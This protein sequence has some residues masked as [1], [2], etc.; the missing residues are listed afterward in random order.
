MEFYYCLILVLKRLRTKKL[1]YFLIP[2][3]FLI[4]LDLFIFDHRFVSFYPPYN[5]DTTEH[6]EHGPLLMHLCPPFG[7]TTWAAWWSPPKSPW[8]PEPWPRPRPLRTFT[9]P[10]RFITS[11]EIPGCLSTQQVRGLLCLNKRSLETQINLLYSIY[12]DRKHRF[13]KENKWIYRFKMVYFWLGRYCT[14]Q[15]ISLSEFPVIYAWI[16]SWT[17]VYLFWLQ[18]RF[19]LIFHLSCRLQLW[20]FKINETVDQ[21]IYPELFWKQKLLLPKTDRKSE[22]VK[23]ILIIKKIFVKVNFDHS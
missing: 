4:S 6:Q 13:G 15:L 22:G 9:T 5:R 16:I 18:V 14:N 3:K 17:V 8:S 7:Y 1:N 2:F 12:P 23:N 20:R 21:V 11:P 10:T 19:E